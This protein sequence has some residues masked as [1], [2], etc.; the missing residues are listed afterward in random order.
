[1]SRIDP[2]SS[3]E[4]RQ[5]RYESELEAN[6]WSVCKEHRESMGLE[7]DPEE[8]TCDEEPCRLFCPLRLVHSPDQ[9][10]G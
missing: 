1:M 3:D 7:G 5:Q 4:Y 2:V 8:V 6:N 9:E 10:R